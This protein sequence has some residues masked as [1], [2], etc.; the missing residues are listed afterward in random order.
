MNLATIAL[1]IT[2]TTVMY[3]LGFV[4]ATVMNVSF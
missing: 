4:T 1:W 3:G 2:Y